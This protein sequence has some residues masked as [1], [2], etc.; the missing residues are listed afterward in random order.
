MTT[1]TQK[2][3]AQFNEAIS[4]HELL[5]EKRHSC[6]ER[7]D[8]V[9]EQQCLD[10]MRELGILAIDSQTQQQTIKP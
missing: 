1:P 5:N 6:Q 4:E 9:G 8:V 2:L 3:Q 10:R 7:G